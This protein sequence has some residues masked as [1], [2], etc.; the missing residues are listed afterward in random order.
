MINGIN[1][2]F[3][4]FNYSVEDGSDP[5]HQA[6]FNNDFQ[7]VGQLL[8]SYRPLCNQ[9]KTNLTLLSKYIDMPKEARSPKIL[10]LFLEHGLLQGTGSFSICQAIGYVSYHGTAAEIEL[11]FNS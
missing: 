9:D 3:N 5:L 4:D 10:Q 7:A 11:I 6:L 8:S 1:R 2:S